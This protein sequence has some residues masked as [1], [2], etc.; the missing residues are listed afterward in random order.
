MI[1]DI[2]DMDGETKEQKFAKAHHEMKNQFAPSEVDTWITDKG[3]ISN[4]DQ[5]SAIN[6]RGEEKMCPQWPG[7]VHD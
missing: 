3:R 2:H 7:R 4:K 1:P 5:N 6:Q